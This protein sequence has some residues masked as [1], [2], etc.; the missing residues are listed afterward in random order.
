MNKKFAAV[1]LGLVLVLTNCTG[2]SASAS[3]L[4]KSSVVIQKS[5]ITL[6]SVLTP[7]IKKT[8]LNNN[9]EKMANVVKKLKNRVNKT[10]YV[11]G[12]ATPKGWDCSGLVIWAYKHFGIKLYHSAYAQKYAAK[13]R[14]Y[15][16]SKVKPGDIIACYGPA[17]THVGIASDKKGYMI[18]SPRRGITTKEDKVLDLF[19]SCT[20]TRLVQT[21]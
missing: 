16:A 18:H 17:G 10:W 2:V 13:P 6:T 15:V 3:Q 12:G 14:K 20:Y 21:V 5:E 9:T 4:N 11:F 1:G 19:S 7:S 8:M